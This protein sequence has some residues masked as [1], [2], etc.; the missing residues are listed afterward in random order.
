MDYFDMNIGFS[1]GAVAFGDF[2]LGLEL[3]ACHHLYGVELSALRGP[4][5][6]PL[7]EALDHLDLHRYRYVSFHAPSRFEAS[8]E[9]RIVKLLEPVVERGWPIICHPD[10]I[11]SDSLWKSIE[12]SLCFENM[13][14]RKPVGRT[15]AELDRIFD[16][17][18]NSA[19]CFDI[20]HAWQLDRTMSEAWQIL[21]R[22]RSRI[23][24]VHVSEVNT[25][26]EHVPLTLASATAFAKVAEYI[27]H[28]VPWIIESV[29]SSTHEIK[30]EIDFVQH[31]FSRRLP[32]LV[33]D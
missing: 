4:E 14:K 21:R 17:F 6:L 8:D 23:K 30:R 11:V 7:I 13:D 19:L 12:S 33:T 16:R 25:H 24:Q 2:R 9:S 22:H 27:P 18:P 1:T 31:F 20:G 32:Q 10:A 26:S 29:I 3:L 28:E 5:L 15:A